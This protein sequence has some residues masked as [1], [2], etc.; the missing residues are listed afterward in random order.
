MDKIFN[1][2][3][4]DY[5]IS[6]NVFTK[7][8]TP[9]RIVSN[10]E[11][12][13]YTV[14]DNK[15][16]VNGVVYPQA[17]GNILISSPGD[18]RYS[19][20]FFE[21]YCVHFLCNDKEIT[22]AINALPKV[23]T[24]TSS[25]K[26]KLIFKNLLNTQSLNGISKTL[27]LQGGMLELISEIIAKSECSYQEKYNRYVPTVFSACDYIEANYDRHITLSDISA[28]VNLSPRFF[29][30]V[31]K[32]I[33]KETPAEFLLKTRIEHAK[34]MLKN[35]N[36]S[37]SEIALKCGFGSQGYFNYVFKNHTHNT[38]GGYRSKKQIII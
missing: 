33:K 35:S 10:Y 20:G 16:V 13:L 4:A 21:C 22:D 38:P 6:K 23:F 1:I 25:D 9:K 15:S 3:R 8:Q 31:F 28:F 24:P 2:S 12:E 17:P 27:A 32:S 29:H 37:L 19:I 5:Y 7:L 26:S 11:I 18:E 14:T 36:A 30:G 34:D